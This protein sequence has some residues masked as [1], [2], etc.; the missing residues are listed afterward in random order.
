METRLLD[1]AIEIVGMGHEG[2]RLGGG[3]PSRL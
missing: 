2:L 1:E 3:L